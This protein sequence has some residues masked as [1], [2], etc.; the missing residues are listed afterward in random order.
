MSHRRFIPTISWQ[1]KA[2]RAAISCLCISFVT[3]SLTAQEITSF[4]I[5]EYRVQGAKRLKSLE[6]EE[7]VYPFLGP[8]RTP[9]DVEQARVALEKVY[10]A[11]G[12]QT[13]SVVVPQQDPRRGIIRLEVVEGKV[14]RLRVNGARFFLPSRIKA[15]A[16]SVAEGT[17]P[18]LEDFKKDNLTLNRN[19][20]RR[21]TPALRTGV[22]PG[23]YDIDLNV[24]DELPLHG[25]LE[26]NN[27]N[28]ADT[29]GLRLNGAASYSNLYQLGHTVGFNFQIAPQR[30]ADA[31]VY[32]AYYL[33]RVSDGVSLML[34]GTKQNSDVSTIGGAA[35]AGRGEI[36]GLRA[37]FDLPT[38]PEFYQNVSV[39]I[40]YKNLSE[41]LIIGKSTSSSPIEYYP[42]SANYG[43]TW[44]TK[45]GFTELNHSVSAGLRGLG[46]D[47]DDYGTRRYNA[48]GSFL[49]LRS[50][51][52]HT[53]DLKGGSQIFGKIQGQLS[54]QPLVN[55]EQFSG[56]G[57]GTAR[58]Y[59][60]STSLGD[61]GIF[62]TVE[63]RTPSLLGE[64][65]GERSKAQEWRIYA[66][67]DSGLLGIYDALPSQQK[68]FGFASVG[69][70]TR[71][72]VHEH[73][74][75]SLDVAAPL[76]D[77]PYADVGDVRVTFRSWADF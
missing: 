35:S 39:G 25:S 19:P 2:A 69:L 60:E 45:N 3:Q 40:D 31:Q 14:G 41:D 21:V 17:L 67:S 57:L 71:F 9:D 26:L 20:D 22:E 62:G 48:S 50:D 46:S 68:Q 24:E 27:R 38:Q 49:F 23:T 16:P 64:S 47:E 76:I 29:T 37:M 34:T 63:L 73:Y 44:M 52:A 42:L 36:V 15:E 1:S 7:A 70:G 32:S 53:H 43:A 4:N 66:F 8:A 74:D 55:S 10:H 6:V 12:Y 58:G 72:R 56:G 13:V 75:G 28:S 59:L 65:T 61:N 18:N 30:L 77:K 54:S 5:R 33:A 11:K 51:L